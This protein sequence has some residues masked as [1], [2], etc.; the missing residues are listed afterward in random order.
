MGVVERIAS[1]ACGKVRFQAVGRPIVASVCYCDDCQAGGRQLEAMGAA[2]TF[3]D[4]WRGSPYATYRDLGLTCLEG[5]EFLQGVKLRADAPTTR[6]IAT[7]CKSPVYLKYAPGWWTTV[8]R[9]RFSDPPP[10]EFRSSTQ[11]APPGSVLPND[12]PVYRSFP[13]KLFARLF[14]AGIAQLLRLK[15]R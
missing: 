10:L 7:C 13:P 1:C 3:H 9:V 4:E 8:Y 5:R 6:F 11:Y 2:P 14:V 15:P 12:V